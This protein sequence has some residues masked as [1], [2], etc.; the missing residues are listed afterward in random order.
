MLLSRVNP[1]AE[2]INNGTEVSSIE[3]GNELSQT[4]ETIECHSNEE[5]NPSKRGKRIRKRKRKQETGNDVEKQEL[6]NATT[7]EPNL[8][9]QPKKLLKETKKLLTELS[10]TNDVSVSSR[11]TNSHIRSVK[12]DCKDHETSVIYLLDSRTTLLKLM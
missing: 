7:I 9:V 2:E 10:L 4:I 6:S 5:S 11:K 3:S 8:T 12:V 1:L